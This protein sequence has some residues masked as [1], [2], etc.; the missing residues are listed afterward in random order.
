MNDIIIRRKIS[1]FL[2]DFLSK[3]YVDYEEDESDYIIRIPKEMIEI[4]DDLDSEN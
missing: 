4:D 1:E 2:R 3:D